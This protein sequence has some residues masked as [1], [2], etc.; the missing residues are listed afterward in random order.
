VLPE[1]ALSTPILGRLAQQPGKVNMASS[2]IGASPHVAGELFKTAARDARRAAGLSETWLP[3]DRRR[4]PQRRRAAARP[5]RGRERP[6]GLAHLERRCPPVLA[7]KLEQV[8][9]KEEDGIV[10][11]LAMEL[12]EVTQAVGTTIDPL[13]VD[14][15]RSGPELGGGR[16]DTR[17]FADPVEPD[18]GGPFPGTD[19]SWSYQEFAKISGR[20]DM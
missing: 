5:D 7:V 9:A 14:R 10:V 3:A 16:D 15:D 18:S 20:C 1:A 4:P 17:I 12:V 8:E 11:Q 2:G 13:A 19:I 6:A